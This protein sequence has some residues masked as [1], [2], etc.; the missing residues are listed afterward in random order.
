[1]QEVLVGLR[2][3]E[4]VVDP[5]GFFATHGTIHD[6][7][8]H[9][10]EVAEFEEVGVD[11]VAPVEFAHFVA[12]VAE[13]VGCAFEAVVG[14]DDGDIV[15]HQA[16]DFVPIV[17]DDHKFVRGCGVAVFPIGDDGSIRRWFVGGVKAEGFREGAAGHDISLEEGVGGQAICAMEPGAGDFSD[18]EEPTD[19]G[20]SVEVGD[21]AA[22]LVVG[23]GDDRNRGLLGIMPKGEEGLINEREPFFHEARGLVGDIEENTGSAGAL[24]FVVDG[25]RHDVPGG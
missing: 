6:E 2:V 13:A 22:T 17:I 11:A 10:D 25:S 3:V 5:T 19:G 23:G 1:V 9:G 20:F 14:A 8:G 21:H 4:G 12:Q 16:S 7:G 18:G 24:E 15:P